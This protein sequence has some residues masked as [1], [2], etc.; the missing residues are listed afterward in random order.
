MS[1]EHSEPGL[2]LEL[3]GPA[4]ED[5]SGRLAVCRRHLSA[6][7]GDRRAAPA[8]SS[9]HLD[10]V[11]RHRVFAGVAAL[12][13]SVFELFD[14]SCSDRVEDVGVPTGAVTIRNLT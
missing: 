13:M 5:W 4:S 9:T 3:A 7:A 1:N 8:V 6:S 10:C 12:I 2:S 14:M 11:L